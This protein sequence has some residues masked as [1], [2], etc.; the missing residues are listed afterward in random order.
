MTQ[1]GLDYDQCTPEELNAKI[2]PSNRPLW[3]LLAQVENS[4]WNPTVAA[5]LKANAATRI[6]F[7]VWSMQTMQ[8]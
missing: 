2:P 7:K 6:F 1:A 5:E 4:K 3:D 8:I